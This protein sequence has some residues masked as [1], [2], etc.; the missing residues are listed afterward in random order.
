[1]TGRDPLNGNAGADGAST[2]HEILETLRALEK[3]VISV[4]EWS[5]ES[6]DRLQREL[7]NLQAVVQ[8][9][10]TDNRQLRARLEDHRARLAVAEK[11]LSTCHS[12]LKSVDD[13][14]VRNILDVRGT[15]ASELVSGEI[16]D[17]LYISRSEL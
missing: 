15:T 8:Q 2:A 3:S 12:H 9:Q 4:T 17:E 10:G 6:R 5:Q 1:M 13:E 14:I 16:T 7:Y 11:A